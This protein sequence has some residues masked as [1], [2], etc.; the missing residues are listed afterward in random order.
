MTFPTKLSHTRTQKIIKLFEDPNTPADVLLKLLDDSSD[1]Y[2]IFIGQ[3]KDKG[4]R[5]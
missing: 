5:W 2:N 3:S 4:S 1:L